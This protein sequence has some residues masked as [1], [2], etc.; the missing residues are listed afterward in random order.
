MSL[1][2]DLDKPYCWLLEW[3]SS[4]RTVA[5]YGSLDESWKHLVKSRQ[6]VKLGTSLSPASQG[7]TGR[8]WYLCGP[9][10]VS[11]SLVCMRQVRRLVC[12]SEGSTEV[13]SRVANLLEGRRDITST[14]RSD[15]ILDLSSPA[16]L[17]KTSAMTIWRASLESA[18]TQFGGTVLARLAGSP[19]RNTLD[20]AKYDIDESDGIP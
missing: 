1:R 12:N 18:L 4:S 3:I 5:V 11:S 16:K 7:L 6:I 8:S 2:R 13:A 19:W 10:L 14:W 17:S 20:E 9:S 15:H